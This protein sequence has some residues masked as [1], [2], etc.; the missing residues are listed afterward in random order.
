MGAI[1][2]ELPTE[3]VTIEPTDQVKA[4]WLSLGLGKGL[5][6]QLESAEILLVPEESQRDGVKYFF[7]QDTGA[8]YQFLQEKLDG[9]VHVEL[10]ATDDEYVE[11]ALHSSIHR[12]GAIVVTYAIAP[13][14]V[15]LL[16]SYVYDSLHAKPNDVVEATLIVEDHECK[17][18]KFEYK[19]EVKDFQALTDKVGQLA[20]DC[21]A[22]APKDRSAKR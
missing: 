19:G 7:H 14:L 20:R 22:K 16:S 18:F 15:N 8:L 5:E 10:C 21:E 13:L 11:V 9:Q 3:R 12:I 4:Y 6:Q 1:W 2:D 17:A